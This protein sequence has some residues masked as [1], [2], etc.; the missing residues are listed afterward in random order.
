MA[1]TASFSKGTGLLTVLGDQADNTS[2][3]SRDA[4]GDIL[5]NGG[6]VVVTGGPATVANT[7]QVQVF[8]LG[9]NDTIKIDESNGAMP[10]ALLFGGAVILAGVLIFAI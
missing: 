1:T 9:G 6:A 4:A 10:A 8:G 7:I 3:V 2:V 5:V